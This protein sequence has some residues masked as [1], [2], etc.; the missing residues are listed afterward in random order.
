MLQQNTRYKNFK[1][2][3]YTVGDAEQFDKKVSLKQYDVC[4][5]NTFNYMFHKFKKGIFIHIKDNKIFKFV[6]FCKANFINEFANQLQ[7]DPNEWKSFKH[8]FD[9]IGNKTELTVDIDLNIKHG[10]WANNGLVRYEKPKIEVDVGVDYIYKLIEMCTNKY[11]ISDCTFFVNK[12]DF[13]ILT[14]DCTEPYDSIWK[15][16][17][18]LVSHNYEKYAS[19]L[20]MTTGVNFKDIAIPT[21]DDFTCENDKHCNYCT[22]WESKKDVAVFRGSSTGLGTTI[23]KNMRLKLLEIG[24]KNPN[25][26]DVGITKWNL[27]PRKLAGDPYYRTISKDIVDKFGTSKYMTYE[28]QSNYKYI[29]NLPGHTTSFRLGSLFKLKSVVLHVLHPE[30]KIWYDHLLKP[31]IHYVP[32]RIDLRDLVKQIEWCKKN[33]IACKKIADNAY[34]FY[35]NHLTISMQCKFTSNILQ[36]IDDY[37]IQHPVDDEKCEWVKDKCKI[38]VNND[39][40]ECNMVSHIC[41]N[42][43]F[44]HSQNTILYKEQFNESDNYEV[45][46]YKRFLSFLQKSYTTNTIG[47]EGG[48]REIYGVCK[49]NGKMY[50]SMKMINGHVSMYDYLFN[51]KNGD[52]NIVMDCIQQLC[53]L[54][55]NAYHITKFVHDD[56]VPWNILLNINY[57]YPVVAYIQNVNEEYV[58]NTPCTV[59]LID[60]EK[61]KSSTSVKE[62]RDIF[63]L[64]THVLFLILTNLHNW[65]QNVINSCVGLFN[66][67]YPHSECANLKDIIDTLCLFKK[68]DNMTSVNLGSVNTNIKLYNYMKLFKLVNKHFRLKNFT[69]RKIHPNVDN[70]MTQYSK[71]K[72]N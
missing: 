48:W 39:V 35:Q 8:M 47:V 58:F 42:K 54:L 21:W 15:S 62:C 46:N 27:R 65:P 4:I 71:L 10:W 67:I 69:V 14:K 34:Q 1:Q 57:N 24:K 32:V 60:Y 25:I 55:N 36:T 37:S 64:I 52:I 44:Y 43:K 38:D 13:P 28:E 40:I 31:Y 11:T 53:V 26:L 12:R 6:P 72:T 23:R 61:S 63:N 33:P 66:D 20:S 22:E 70:L 68:Y 49:M 29:I 19:I 3:F 30:Y 50:T 45:Y 59:Y 17:T 41:K 16:K 18:G 5:Q 9:I 7:V 2:Q 51:C 56:C